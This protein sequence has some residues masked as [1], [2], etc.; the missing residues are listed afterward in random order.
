[1]STTSENKLMEENIRLQA[2]VEWL[3]TNNDDM[4]IK[5]K[6]LKCEMEDLKKAFEADKAAM[7]QNYNRVIKENVKVSNNADILEKRL[8]T[9][10][11]NYD[12]SANAFNNE[13]KHLTK[14]LSEMRAANDKMAV[15][16]RFHELCAEQYIRE[17]NKL[18]ER[19][20]NLK[21]TLIDVNKGLQNCFKRLSLGEA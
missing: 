17:N 15:E 8:I 21:N 11:K 7:M 4:H 2:R 19:H 13:I 20:A 5:N 1:M 6:K 9:T 18:R 12:E 16:C 10:I 3:F 14:A